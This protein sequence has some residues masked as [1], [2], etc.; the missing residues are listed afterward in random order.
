MKKNK[1]R[2]TNDNI[3]EF[4]DNLPFYASNSELR[5]QYISYH[6]KENL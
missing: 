4:E 3:D 2:E 6:P 5:Q 1:M